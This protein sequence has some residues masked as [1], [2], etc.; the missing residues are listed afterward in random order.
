[1]ANGYAFK[2]FFEVVGSGVSRV[3]GI[4]RNKLTVV[5]D[6][7]KEK[8]FTVRG[9]AKQ[10]KC[11]VA[12]RCHLCLASYASKVAQLVRNCSS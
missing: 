2:M 5:W 4:Y 12:D 9:H 8:I 3:G 6:G 1:M 10:M 11:S 7:N